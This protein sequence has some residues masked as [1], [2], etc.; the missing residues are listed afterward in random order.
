MHGPKED[1]RHTTAENTKSKDV[2]F[3]LHI[4]KCAGRTCA[5]FIASN[6][7][8]INNNRTEFEGKY[9]GNKV[10]SPTKRKSPY[11]YFGK[12]YNWTHTIDTDSKDFVIGHHITKS[13]IKK[14]KNR[15][16]KE[17]VLVRDPIGHFFSHYNFRMQK[18]TNAGLNAFGFDI[19]YKSRR[20]DPISK[21]ILAYLEISLFKRFVLSDQAKLDLILDALSGFWHVAESTRTVEN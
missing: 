11:R 4:P 21:Y 3:M 12:R 16:I 18:Y 1:I 13:L 14:F 20:S 9:S 17:T 2:Y 7:G 19:W 6:F 15:N 8:E 5:Y 10:F